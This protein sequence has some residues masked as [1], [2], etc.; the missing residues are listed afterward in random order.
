MHYNA[1]FV[2]NALQCPLFR[3]IGYMGSNVL[4]IIKFQVKTAYDLTKSQM[5]FT[6]SAF[7]ETIV[8]GDLVMF[9]FSGHGYH[10]NGRTYLARVDDDLIKSDEDVQDYCTCVERIFHQLRQ[11]THPL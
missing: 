5:V 7:S 8:D 4:R 10:I 2:H 1:L 9:Y 6:I 3:K 11:K